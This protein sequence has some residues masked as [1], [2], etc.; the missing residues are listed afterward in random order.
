MI[1]ERL[2]KLAEIEN[3]TGIKRNTISA[4]RRTLGIPPNAHGYTYEQV[5]QL[6]KKPRRWQSPSKMAV[7]EL[8]S[9]LKNDGMV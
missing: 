8:K 2:Y 5:R 7:N 1:K 9:K 6:I 3:A 4:R